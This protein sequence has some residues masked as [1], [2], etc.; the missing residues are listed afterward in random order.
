MHIFNKAFET[1]IEPIKNNSKKTKILFF[2]SFFMFGFAIF[3]TIIGQLPVFSTRGITRIFSFVWLFLVVPVVMLDYKFL[4][5]Q[6][7]AIL[8]IV[9]P[10]LLYLFIALFF[11][12]YSFRF[13]ATTEVFLSIYILLISA[14]LGRFFKKIHLKVCLC[15]YYLASLI[16][17]IIVY[18]S[19]LRGVDI[20][21]PMY[22]VSTKNSTGPIL[23]I[24][25]FCA[26]YIFD[27]NNILHLL[28]N[29]ISF[30]FFVVLI[31]LMKTRTVL[32]ALPF[33]VVAIILFKIKN[34]FFKFLLIMVLVAVP[35]IILSV[36][37]LY[38]TIVLDVLF[39]GRTNLDDIF[40]GRLSSIS[41]AFSTFKPF[42]GSGNTYVD[43]MP[44]CFLL[45]YGVFGLIS[46]LP[47][48]TIPFLSL[49]SKEMRSR[50]LVFFAT[51]ITILF[52]FEFL[53]EGFGY[54]GPGARSFIFWMFAG[55]GFNSTIEAIKR[56]SLKEKITRL[57][58]LVYKIKP[59]GFLITCFIIVCSLT[60]LLGVTKLMGINIYTTIISKIPTSTV[61]TKFETP[62]NIE[63]VYPNKICVGQTAT[64]DFVA[65]NKK[66]LD[67]QGSLHSWGD[68]YDKMVQIN[69][70]NTI[71][72]LAKG[73]A[74]FGYKIKRSNPGYAYITIVDPLN[75]DFADLNIFS[76]DINPS[77]GCVELGINTNA[78]V[79]YDHNYVPNNLPHNVMFKYYSSNEEVVTVSSD[80]NLKGKNKG[81]CDVY[82]AILINDKI[83]YKSNS[84]HVS[85]KNNEEFVPV[86]KIDLTLKN[87]DFIYQY[88][89]IDLNVTFNE[90]AS[91]TNWHF[92]LDDSAFEY[93]NNKL[94]F[95]NAGEYE[96]KI[97][98]NSNPSISS[99]TV[100][101]S[102]KENEPISFSCPQQRLEVGKIYTT[103]DLGITLKFSSGNSY[104]VSND[105][106]YRPYGD[107]TGRA[108][109]ETNGLIIN[110]STLATVKT[111]TI[112]IILFSKINN[113]ISARFSFEVSKYTESQIAN[114]ERTCL[115]ILVQFILSFQYIALLFVNFKNKYIKLIINSIILIDVL[116]V[117]FVI[118][119]FSIWVLITSILLFAAF[120]LSELFLLKGKSIPLLNEEEIT[121]TK[122]NLHNKIKYCSVEI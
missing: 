81:E 40:S 57:D 58:M 91:F 22:A 98:S 95:L 36:P 62:G 56:Q 68:Q 35:I 107:F 42:L 27:K 37:Q 121:V 76:D 69:T 117:I 74:C 34:S 59:T 93:N 97:V 119:G 30:V 71:T 109:T 60:N 112:G 52:A 77:T 28:I 31:A 87:E 89:P 102:V 65:E 12:I 1:L 103:E 17:A 83:K 3:L 73:T 94:K 55:F 82:G 78:Y 50:G 45:S 46:L 90:N 18:F 122:M 115:I 104:L 116:L 4:L 51:L 15:I 11:K 85:V 21:G 16:Y 5:K 10:F 19:K 2:V 29:I 43:C 114:M 66:C 8:I 88:E 24:A 54:I 25:V 75:Y 118:Y 106:L 14:C 26:F 72:A 110:N 7:F 47:F 48:L 84:I 20:S 99:N 39:N 61:V 108:W 105:D 111:G 86:N 100:K 70:N 63:L 120:L 49:F 64:I 53:F 13:D 38:K 41:N 32:V 96:L 113:D 9:S 80:G 44:V 67:V 6:L 92:E 79:C 101:I 33:L 23:L